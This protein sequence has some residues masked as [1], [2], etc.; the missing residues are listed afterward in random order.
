[1]DRIS[2][3]DSGKAESPFASPRNVQAQ[4][5]VDQAIVEQFNIQLEPRQVLPD[6]WRCS[7]CS[8]IMPR[9]ICPPPLVEAE[10]EKYLNV[11]LTVITLTAMGCL[12]M[13]TIVVHK[14]VAN[15][16]QPI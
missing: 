8:D 7:G 14:V 12:F 15:L 10:E 2:S 4:D 6:E 11:N 1:M 16:K 5:E 13:S 9:C 3:G